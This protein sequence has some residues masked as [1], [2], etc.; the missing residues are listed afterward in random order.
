M[1][2]ARVGGSSPLPGTT[3]ASTPSLWIRALSLF[4]LALWYPLARLMAWMSWRV[5]P[6]RRHV[7]VANLKASF[8]EWDDATRERVIRE[9]YRGFADMLVEILHSARMTRPEI[10]RR[11]LLKNPQ[12]IRDEVARGKPVLVVAAHQCNWEW[13]LLAFSAQLG[14]PVDAAYK[15]LV[16]NWAER[17]MLKLRSR[18]GARLIPAQQLLGDI[19]QQR[20]AP[21]VIAMVADQEPVSSERK[22]WVRF[23]NRD[24]AFFLGAEEIARTTRYAAFFVKLRRLARGRYEAEFV[25]LA[26]AGEQLAAGEFTARYARM[27][28]EQI[29]AAPADWPWSHKRWKLKKPLYG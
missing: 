12:L 16:D 18:F 24:T 19:I 22:Q 25:P 9:Y 20:N 15:P 1:R 23:L 5:I 13:M 14:I 11:V 29:R 7:V 17:E 3:P 6:Y 28:E 10:E 26:A 2:N 4:P 8:P 21:R 27:V